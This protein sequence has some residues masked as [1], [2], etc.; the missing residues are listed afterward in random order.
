MTVRLQSPIFPR[1]RVTGPITGTSY[2]KDYQGFVDV[3]PADVHALVGE[4][5]SRSFSGFSVTGQGTVNTGA[6]AVEYSD[7]IRHKTVLTVDTVLPAIAGGAD[8]AVG[9][10]LYT[11]PAGVILVEAA[12][13]SLAIT[14]TTA[15]ITADTPDGGLGTTIGSGVVNVLGGNA[16][17]ENILT[18]QTFN[19]CDGTAEV[20]SSAPALLIAAG[21]NKTVYFSVADGWAAD[22]D[23]AA[24][25][26]GTVVL[27]WRRLD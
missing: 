26:A 13:M 15:K 12:Y 3:D 1:G 2:S 4:G 9:K 22:G 8:L 6:T 21:G 14:Q 7:G 11:L 18:G 10:L 24:I 23:P 16:A 17:F 27:H 19:D 25:L 20:A 5:Y